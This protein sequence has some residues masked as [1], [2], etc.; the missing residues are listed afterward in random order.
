MQSLKLALVVVVGV[1]VEETLV[2]LLLDVGGEVVVLG[3]TYFSL[4]VNNI[5]ILDLIWHAYLHEA[6][7]VVH[8]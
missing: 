8:M 4:L 2:V 3:F 1:D 7:F 5:I 6:R